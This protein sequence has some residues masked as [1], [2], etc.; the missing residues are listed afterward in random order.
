MAIENLSDVALENLINSISNLTTFI[1][2]IGG[3]ILIY[4]VFN[5]I[6]AIFNR[7]KRNEL[8]EINKNLEEIKK[9]LRKKSR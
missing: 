6:N 2:A 9:I 7:K 3:V 4:L 5:I 1:Q 8:R